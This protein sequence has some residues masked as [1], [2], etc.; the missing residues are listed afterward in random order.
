[1]EDGNVNTV[2]VHFLK[3]GVLL[4]A[5]ASFASDLVLHVDDFKPD[6][7]GRAPEGW[8]TFTGGTQ[9]AVTVVRGK[10]KAYL[11][12]QRSDFDGLVALSRSFET[13]QVRVEVEFSFA[14][15]EGNGRSLNLWSH[16]PNG[17]DASQLNICIQQGA[18][19]QF[20]GRTR[21]W[22][23]IS[24]RITPSA[25][26]DNPVWHRLRAVID[27]QKGGIDFWLSN[28]GSDDLPTEPTATLQAYRTGLPLAGL[29]LVSGRRIAAGAWYLLDNLVV[30][31]GPGHP[32]YLYP[33]LA[34]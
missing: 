29:D 4:M 16:A 21:T 10:G 18:L 7:A 23:V 9:P 5:S 8:T 11:R 15:S 14:F 19:R 2:T 17:R 1:M 22:E 27:S 25:N 34:D 26:V 12:G 28:P 13:P 33:G 24:R 6:E 31:G 20:D 30:H 3:L 32:R